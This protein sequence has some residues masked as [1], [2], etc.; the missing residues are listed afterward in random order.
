MSVIS[1]DSEKLYQL[2]L[3]NPT[4]YK[5]IKKI[6][7]VKCVD[8]II[9]S[10]MHNE[11]V[12]N[13]ITKDGDDKCIEITTKIL[14]IL[15]KNTKWNN[16][17]LIY[18]EFNMSIFWTLIYHKIFNLDTIINELPNLNNYNNPKG[19]DYYIS[20]IIVLWY[21]YKPDH[22]KPK[23]Y[24]NA[25]LT[26]IGIDSLQLH[27]N[28]MSCNLLK[29]IN[30]FRQTSKTNRKKNSKNFDLFIKMFLE[31]NI[32][33]TNVDIYKY[34]INVYNISDT[35]LLTY[36]L[37]YLSMI[38]IIT[39]H[40]N[41]DKFI[42]YYHKKI[43]IIMG[44]SSDYCNCVKET[45]SFTVPSKLDYITLLE[46]N[47]EYNK[48]KDINVYKN[49]HIAII[50]NTNH[51][52]NNIETEFRI[53][54]KLCSKYYYLGNFHFLKKSERLYILSRKRY[55]VI[56]DK[57][58][59]D[60]MLNKICPYNGL[61]EIITSQ[62]TNTFSIDIDDIIYI[63]NNRLYVRNYKVENNNISHNVIKLIYEQDINYNKINDLFKYPINN[64]IIINNQFSCI[65][66]YDMK[67]D[68][69]KKDKNTIIG[70]ITALLN[71]S[72]M[73]SKL[74]RVSHITIIF[75]YLYKNIGFIHDNHNFHITLIKKILDFYNN[76]EILNYIIKLLELWYCYTI[77]F[78]N[79]TSQNEN[80]ILINEVYNKHI[81][82]SKT[83]II[84][85]I[86]DNYMRKNN[87]TDEPNISDLYNSIYYLKQMISQIR[88][89]NKLSDNDKEKLDYTSPM[90]NSL[91][92]HPKHKY[93]QSLRHVQY[94]E[95]YIDDL[96]NKFIYQTPI[97][98]KYDYMFDQLFHCDIDVD[99]NLKTQL[100]EES[101][102]KLL[103][104]DQLA[105]LVPG[106]DAMNISL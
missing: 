58:K 17:K 64:H 27:F 32:Y 66:N 65:N 18:D 46:P 90:I 24:Y 52:I 47:L 31:N 101:N 4:N 9:Q 12:I 14:S 100:I 44:M 59:L 45:S 39:Y 5:L 68:Y 16:I 78:N 92:T 48:G 49:T 60:G 74:T 35:L 40:P 61:Y 105:E 63:L 41:Y 13:F 50:Y 73:G 93:Y 97:P 34:I 84:K 96:H 89:Y 53:N 3:Y 15:I 88:K 91:T 43:K 33:S 20:Y 80:I 98:E 1:N 62:T 42:N 57:I 11:D 25:I 81:G 82:I 10:L 71:A 37:S 104:L 51:T 36:N 22:K 79:T 102:Q 30:K 85:S 28:T 86:I 83:H 29:C 99:L 19:Y 38:M 21:C 55:E 56:N 87:I 2:F 77:K 70:N 72:S 76:K 106:F 8:N 23:H 7:D 94:M 6:T 26:Q 75:N 54:N 69:D 103:T 67:F 95:K